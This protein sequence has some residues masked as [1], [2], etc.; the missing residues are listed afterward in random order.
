MLPDWL[1]IQ[2]AA[3][4]LNCSV[5]TIYRRIRSG[6]LP[7]YKSG[8]LTRIKRDDLDKLFDEKEL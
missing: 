7:A 1:T 4:Y 2:Q 5:P 6:D 8:K 3:E